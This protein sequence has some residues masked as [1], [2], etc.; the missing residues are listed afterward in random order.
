L[1][2]LPP[3]EALARLRELPGVGP[4]TAEAVLLRGCGLVDAVPSTEG[5]SWEA[6]ATL[7]GVDAADD[8]AIARV[9]DGWRPYR[10]WATVLVR[11]G[12]SRQAGVIR[13]RPRR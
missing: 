8:A 13:Y 10:M 11:V 5:A 9:T 1:R 2:S 4:F 3:D 6:I 12:W 7:Y